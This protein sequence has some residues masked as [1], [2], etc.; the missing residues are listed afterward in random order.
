MNPKRG[1]RAAP[2]PAPDEWDVRFA[3]EGAKGW[4]QLSAQA[5]SNTR[6]AS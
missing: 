2:P 5:A 4:E 6:A 1:D 3:T